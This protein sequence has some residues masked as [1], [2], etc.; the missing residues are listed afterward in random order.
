MSALPLR[1]AGAS[2]PREATGPALEAGRGE[3]TEAEITRRLAESP[4][5]VDT[6]WSTA[7]EVPVPAPR[8]RG[9]VIAGSV[10]A[11]GHVGDMARVSPVSPWFRLQVGYEPLD[12]LMIFA[13]ADLALS[14]TAYA[15]RPPA[16]RGYALFGV[17]LG[18]EL[19][20]QPADSVKLFLQAGAG[21]ASVDRD[22]LAT[23]G[24]R[25]ADRLSPQLGGTVG[26]D[27]LQVSPHYALTVFGGARDYLDTFRRLNGSKPPLAW[28]GGLGLRYAL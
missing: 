15:S 10:G 27:W 6:G 12:W 23:Y 13:E 4:G 7:E 5:D 24:Y 28:V 18:V 19:G 17:G 21:L 1:A 16:K 26:L 14:S 11:L 9:V 8:E 3:L 20:W 22:V 2:E 25:D